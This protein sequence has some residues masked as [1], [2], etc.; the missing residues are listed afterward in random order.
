MPIRLENW[1]VAYGTK[2]WY[3]PPELANIVLQGQMYGHEKIPDG[4]HVKSGTILDAEGRLITCNE[5]PGTI[6]VRL[7]R[8]NK[9][10]RCWLRKHRP[11]WNWRDPVTIFRK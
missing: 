11:E 5:S 1:S 6:K 8:I 9:E 10:Y 4:S 2:D 3:T 7:G